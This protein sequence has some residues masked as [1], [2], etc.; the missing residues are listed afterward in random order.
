ME[1]HKQLTIGLFGFGVVG[2]GLYKVLQQTPSLNAAIKKICIKN[3]G[4][5][6]NAPA[7]LFTTDKDELLNDH[8]INV[9][10]EV[11][12]DADAAFH[13]VTTALK[14][15]KN[16]V[17]ASKKM[18]AEHLPFL[19]ELQQQTGRSFLYESAACASIP[20]IRNLE[21]YY[22]NDLL[23]SIKAIVNGSTNFILTKIFEEGLDFKQALVLAQQLGF[24]ES[25]PKL[26]VEGYDAVN[27][28]TL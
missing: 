24:A 7:S 22:D 2:E 15:G 28:W 25:N 14:N 9:I 20:V 5:K 1:T 19:L 23:H 13:I 12:D 11:I 17:S 21:E 6:R 27:K 8:D 3:Y 18:I 10:V 16:V 4:K 26:D